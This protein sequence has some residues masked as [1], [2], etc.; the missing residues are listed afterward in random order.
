M[1]YL[2]DTDVVID[3]LNRL[4]VIQ[5]MI[6]RLQGDGVSICVVTY[7]EVFECV[8]RGVDQGAARRQFEAF[9]TSVPVIR[10]TLLE[11]EACAQVRA[12]LGR[13]GRRSRTA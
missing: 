4:T 12:D 1:P 13:R 9:L 7:V 2:L 11:A 10:F 6:L 8:L 5:P 3:W